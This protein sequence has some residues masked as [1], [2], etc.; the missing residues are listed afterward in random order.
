VN[1]KVGKNARSVTFKVLVG[2]D[3]DPTKILIGGNNAQPDKAEFTL[4]AHPDR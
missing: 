1:F 4:P 2:G 3:D